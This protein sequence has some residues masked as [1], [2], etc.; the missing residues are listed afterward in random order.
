MSNSVFLKPDENGNWGKSTITDA[1]SGNNLKVNSDGS[2]NV[3]GSFSITPSGTQTINND[4]V[5]VTMQNA[6]TATGNGSTLNTTNQAMAVLDVQGTFSG[7]ITV[8]GTIDGTNYFAVKTTDM[9]S[10]TRVSTITAA[11]QFSLRVSGYQNFRAR[12][13]AYTS[14]SITVYGRAVAGG[15]SHHTAAITNT[16]NVAVTSMPTTTV[17]GTVGITGTPSVLQGGV[18][19]TIALKNFTFFNAATANG[20]TIVDV[21]GYNTISIDAVLSVASGAT[22]TASVS[23]DGVNFT[24]MEY[25]PAS[26]SVAASTSITST[27]RALRFN[28]ASFKYFQITITSYTS[29]TVTV[30]GNANIGTIP[31]SIYRST[32]TG[33]IYVT[34][35]LASGSDVI[36]LSSVSS[37]G[38]TTLGGIQAVALTAMSIYSGTTQ[39]DRIRTNVAY[40][41]SASAARTATLTTADLL[42]YN[43]RG[44]IVTVNVTAVSGTGGLTPTIQLKCASGVYKALNATPTAIT[45]VGTY[46]YAIAVGADATNTGHTQVSNSPLPR[47]F[48]I[49]V[50][51]GDASSYTYSVDVDFMV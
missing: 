2:V 6:A 40:N 16:P 21:S 24:N 45:A 9:S 38:Y 11:G 31:Q 26:A 18:D 51:A 30:T 5:A 20:S 8:E 19:Q 32:S 46:T 34:P 42:T 3:S 25:N 39:V 27:T 28:I 41:A 29:G 43:W 1:T 33:G 35:R 15:V 48:R 50:A 49:N 22:V 10:D 14:G 7:T 12:I 37:D 47:T 36:A 23:N 17:T 4:V 13:S 44:I